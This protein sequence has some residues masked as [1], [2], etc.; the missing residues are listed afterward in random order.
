MKVLHLCS[1]DVVG[2]A[3]LAAYRLHQGL[4]KGG[5]GSQMLVQNKYGQDP[6]VFG[7]S[8]WAGRQLAVAK[9]LVDASPAILSRRGRGATFSPASFPDRLPDEVARITPDLVH[10]HWICGGFVKIETLARLNRP[11][12][13]TVHDMWPFTGGCHYSGACRRYTGSCGCCPELGS[14]AENDLSRRVWQRKERAWRN[15]SI[16]L[17]APSRW[18]ARCVGESSIFSRAEVMVIPNGIDTA[19]FAPIDRS[20]AREMLGLPLD[21]K[22][23]L[24]GAI[25]PTADLRK[26]FGHLLPAI[27]ELASNGWGATTELV[28][29]G[30]DQSS[31]RPDFGMRA[32][33]IGHVS[34]QEKIALLNAAADVVVAPSVQ[35]NLPN[36]VMEAL[37]CGTPVVAFRIGGM[38]DM[39]DHG[40]SGWLADPFD[41]GD[42]ARGIMHVIGDA[43]RRAEMGRAA[44]EKTMREFEIGNVARRYQELY[45]ALS[46]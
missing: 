12:V 2:G 5:T 35:D 33:C 14:D 3:A 28:I 17:V 44:R 15:L 8:S 38:I 16:T 31:P 21:R 46:P 26:G 23:I 9:Y 11:I 32:R 18:M 39:V 10:L 45:A 13:W 1:T 7:S 6:S 34:S 25:S 20:L 27:K 30:S 24:F 37:A 43:G 42:L 4:S 19:L 36:T 22:L 29:C 40:K 41:C